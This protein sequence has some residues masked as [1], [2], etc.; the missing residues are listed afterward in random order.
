[1]VAGVARADVLYSTDFD[2]LS[3][4]TINGQD[5]WVA[6]SWGDVVDDGSPHGNVLQ[7]TSGVGWT[8]ADTYRSY[9]AG[10]KRYA[11]IEMDLKMSMDDN[12]HFWFMD[13]PGSGHNDG[14]I[15]FDNWWSI[16]G[17]ATVY[18]AESASP[19]MDIVADTWYHYAFEIDQQGEGLSPVSTIIGVNRNGTWSLATGVNENPVPAQIDM[20]ILRGDGQVANSTLFI[21]NLHIYDSDTK[22]SPE[23]ATL[24]LLAFGTAG[25]LLRRKK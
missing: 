6:A 18:P 5:S 12:N 3:L 16:P 4:G 19:K 10:T 8:S 21:D 24:A 7:I 1:M 17:Y 23:P 11:I 2:A 25:L 14:T 20:F 22:V 15:Y 9:T 13:N